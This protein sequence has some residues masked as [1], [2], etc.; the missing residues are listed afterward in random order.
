M[1]QDALNRFWWPSIMMFGP[2][3]S[4]S[5]RTGNAMKWKIKRKTNDELRQ[6]FIDKTVAQAELIGLKIPD[7]DLKWN[8]ERGSY[9]FGEIDWDEFWNVVKG[10]GRCNKQRLKHRRKA[11]ENGAWVR[12]AALA[13]AEKRAKRKAE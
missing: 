11:Q 9:D 1:A 6:N 2:N 4:D 7:P 8:E 13:H 10:R 5:P 12:E 3:D